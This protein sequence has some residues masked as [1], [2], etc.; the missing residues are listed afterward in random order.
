MFVCIPFI[1]KQ[2]IT[3]ISLLSPG[4][5]GC[6][7]EV[8]VTDEVNA[9]LISGSGKNKTEKKPLPDLTPI[10]RQISLLDSF[11]SKFF[12]NSVHTVSRN[13]TDDDKEVLQDIDPGKIIKPQI[14]CFEIVETVSETKPKTNGHVE[15]VASTSRSL[16]INSETSEVSD[17]Q[18]T[19]DCIIEEIDNM[20]DNPLVLGMHKNS[21]KTKTDE[22]K[23]VKS[24]VNDTLIDNINSYEG[25]AFEDDDSKLAA[26]AVFANRDHKVNE[27]HAKISE[28]MTL[29][30]TE[31]VL[32]FLRGP[33]ATETI[34]DEEED[35]LNHSKDDIFAMPS[36]WQEDFNMMPMPV[37]KPRKKK[38]LSKLAKK[39]AN[40]TTSDSKNGMETADGQANSAINVTS[41]KGQIW[42]DF[43]EKQGVVEHS[44]KEN[45][46]NPFIPP[47]A[48]DTKRT[49]TVNSQTIIHG[50]HDNK[51]DTSKMAKDKKDS[52][53]DKDMKAGNLTIKSLD[54]LD[55]FEG[56]SLNSSITS[57]NDDL[58]D[59]TDESIGE[60]CTAENNKQKKQN[61]EQPNFAIKPPILKYREKSALI[62]ASKYDNDEFEEDS[63]SA[64]RETLSELSDD[65][66]GDIER[67]SRDN[68]DE[69][70]YDIVTNSKNKRSKTSKKKRRKKKSN[71]QKSDVMGFETPTLDM[72]KYF[73]DDDRTGNN[74]RPNDG[75]QGLISNIKESNVPETTII[76]QEIEKDAKLDKE[77]SNKIDDVNDYLSAIFN[78]YKNN[79]NSQITDEMKTP[80]VREFSDNEF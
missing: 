61:S 13:I 17:D 23:Q 35:D 52:N 64:S 44:T 14:P 19:S 45:S 71:K 72:S 55:L 69:K 32:D 2:E 63:S 60:R 6:L 67:K 20:L 7:E 29:K 9:I 43:Q 40:Q 73:T 15:P 34:I 51:E 11:K 22:E 36:T 75:I 50:D 12:K 42:E 26:K 16:S 53:V 56:I 27:P 38:H 79:D 49:Y 5:A 33:P 10:V 58:G 57:K 25:D 62:D 65:E 66:D 8:D 59:R 48:R 78:K 28:R 47:S 18:S 30:K 3:I 4:M 39:R 54:S 77:Q 24:V 74:G 1:T 41:T 70:D 80:Y 68:D 21:T 31:N 46:N 37:P 76:Q